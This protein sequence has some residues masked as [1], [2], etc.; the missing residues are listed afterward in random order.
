MCRQQFST[1]RFA[2]S[3]LALLRIRVARPLVVEGR[4][5]K[6]TANHALRKAS[7]RATQTIPNLKFGWII[8]LAT[9]PTP[10]HGTRSVSAT[11]AV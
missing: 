3:A 1:E 11:W 4:S 5:G 6:R 10:G 2:S 7:E 9:Q 8:A